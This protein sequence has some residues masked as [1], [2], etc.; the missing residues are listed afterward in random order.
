MAFVSQ[1]SRRRNGTV[2]RSFA[3]GC[4][5]KYLPLCPPFVGGATPPVGKPRA[6]C[7]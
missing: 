1:G 5:C 3:L 2:N 7:P 4:L 6:A